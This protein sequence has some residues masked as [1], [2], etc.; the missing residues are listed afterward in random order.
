MFVLS[1]AVKSQY[2]NKSGIGK[3]LEKKNQFMLQ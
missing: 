3:D 1:A 2:G